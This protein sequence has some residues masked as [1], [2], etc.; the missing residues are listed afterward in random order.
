M[1]NRLPPSYRGS[2]VRFL[3]QV[4]VRGRL[5]PPGEMRVSLLSGTFDMY[6]VA[7]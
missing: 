2:A 1:P 7:W 4:V 5:V 6:D 3:Y